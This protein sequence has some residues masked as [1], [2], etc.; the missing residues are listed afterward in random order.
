MPI[1]SP[2]YKCTLRKPSCHSTCE[3]Y[4]A[5]VKSKVKEKEAE[6]SRRAEKEF[7]WLERRCVRARTKAQI[8][9]Y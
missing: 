9:I 7:Y 8:Q 4:S 2:C 6:H 5:F 1:T 3:A